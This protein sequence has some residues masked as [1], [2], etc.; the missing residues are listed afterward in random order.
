MRKM[1]RILSFIMA[2]VIFIASA[3][4]GVYATEIDES[5]A[6][7]EE[8]VETTGSLSES[9]ETV[10]FTESVG[11]VVNETVNVSTENQQEL[12]D[13][14]EYDDL[15]EM[16]AVEI[17]PDEIEGEV[18][19]ADELAAL[20]ENRPSMMSMSYNLYWDNYTSYY[21]YNQ[22]S[23]DE[24]KLWDALD[25]LCANYLVD[26]TDLKKGLTDYVTINTTKTITRDE[27]L[28]FANMFKY[29]HPQYYYLRSGYSYHIGATSVTLAFMVY[30]AFTDG[31]ARKNATNAVKAQLDTWCEQIALGS[32]EEEK[33]KIIHDIICDNVDYN[34]GVLAGDN[35]I[36]SEEEETYFTQSA[37]SV[38]CTDLTVCAGYTQTFM[39]LCNAFDIECFGVTSPG[40][41]WNKVKVND[42]WYNLD[43]TWDDGVGVGDRDY[44]CYL[45]NDAYM[46]SI[47]GHEEEEEWL[48]YL[49]SCTLDSGSDYREAGTLQVITQKVAKPTISVVEEG[50]AYAVTIESDT[51]G[52]K[53]FY[54]LDG[55][56]PSEA[57]SKGKLYTGTFRMNQTATIRAIA[58]C[59]GYLDSEVADG[60]SIDEKEYI[61]DSGSCGANVIWE[62]DSKDVLTISGSGDMKSYAS[63]DAVPW[64]NYSQDIQIVEIKDGVT[65]IGDYAFGSVT[66]VEYIELADSITKIGAYA[67]TYN[68]LTRIEIP[69]S[70]R[71]IGDYAFYNSNLVEIEIP[72]GV[73]ELGMYAFASCYELTHVKICGNPTTIG[74]RVFEDCD[75]L[76][77]IELS[78]TC[79]KIGTMMFFGCGGLVSIEL[80]ES[81]TEIGQQALSYCSKLEEIR[82]PAKVVMQPYAFYY[83]TGLKKVT[84]ENGVTAIPYGAFNE[85][86]AL[87][88]IR[89]PKSV[90]SIGN[91][92]IDA[93]ATIYGYAG[94]AAETYANDNGNTFVDIG[95]TEYEVHFVTGTDEQIASIICQKNSLIEEP[96]LGNK[97]G[98]TF[99]GWYTSNTIHDETTKW[100]FANDIVTEEMTLYAYWIPNT[101]QLS[102]DLNYEGVGIVYEKEVTYDAPYGLLYE[103]NRIGYTFLGWYTQSEG[104]EEITPESIYKNA[105]DTTIYAHWRANTYTVTLDANGGELDNTEL[106]VTFDDLYGELPMPTKAGYDFVGWFTDK[107]VGQEI[108]EDTKVT[109]TAPQT[110]YA[111]WK[112]SVYEVTFNTTGGEEITDKIEVTFGEPYGELPVAERVGYTF[113][114][115]YTEAEGGA[116]ITEESIYTNVSDT[117]IYAQWSANTYKIYFDANG[118]IVDITE[119]TVTFDELYG[120]LPIP[121]KEGYSFVGWYT[122]KITGQVIEKDTKVTIAQSQTLYARWEI[123]VCEVT[124]NPNGGTVDQEKINVTYGSLYGE[125]PM[126]V[127]IG[128]TF[129]GWY[130]ELEG[131]IK[132]NA[133][134]IV[135]FMEPKTLYAH[136]E[137][138]YKVANPV[139]R[140]LDGTDPDGAEVALGTR[141][142]LITDT[143]GAK[144]YFTKDAGV[145]LVLSAENGTLTEVAMLYEDAIELTE[146]G[147]LYAIAV[148]EGYTYSEVMTVSY[149]VLDD[150]YNWGDVTEEDIEEQ[151]FSTTADVPKELWV[152][153]VAEE[154]NYTGK[155]ITYPELRVYSYTTLLKEKT[156]Y[157]VKYKN[158]KNAGIATITITGKGNYSGSIVKTFT[159]NPLNLTDAQI[160]DVTLQYN[161][162]VQKP[163][164]TVKYELDGKTVTL[165]KGTDFNYIYPGTD[166]NAEDYDADAFK[167][168]GTYTVYL[169]GKGNY[170]TE[171]DYSVAFEVTIVEETLISKM[172]L[173]KIPNQKYTGEEITPSVTLMRGS[174]KL[175]EGNDYEIVEYINNVGVGTAS[176]VIEGMGDYVGTRTAT[177]KITGTALSKVRMSG[178]AKSLPWTGEEVCQDDVTF[179]YT[180]GKGEEAYT[181]YLEKDIHYTVTYQKNVLVGTATVIFEGIEENGYTGTIKKTYKITGLPMKNVQVTGLLSTIAY[182]GGDNT[183]DGYE[184]VYIEGK[185]EDAQEISL[186][187][188]TEGIGEGDY[189]VSY[190]N[191]GKAGTATITFTGINGYTGSIKKTYKIT[192]YDLADEEGRI[193][194]SEI[195]DQTYLKGGAMPKPEVIYTTTYGEEILLV[196]GK[197]YTLKYSNNKSVA[198]VTMRKAPMVT[199]TGKGNFKGKQMHKFNI[200]GSNLSATTMIAT[201]VVYQNKA[202]IC[203]P[204]IKV[205]DADGK[206]L[207]SNT[208]YQKTVIYKYAADVEVTQKVNNKFVNEM[209]FKGDDV[210]K[211]DIIPVGAEI[212]ATVTGIKNY[213]GTE[214]LPSTQSATFKF[215][216]ADIAKAKV[217]V[218]AQT[219]TGKTVEPTKEDITVKIGKITLEK[220]D[221]EIVGYS[222]NIKKGTA[223]VTIRG[224]GNYGGEKTVTFK[225]N[226]KSMNYTIIF[227]KNADDA[228]GT[229][230]VASISAGK[231]LTANAY[232]NNGYKFVGWNTQADGSGY[233]Y[234]DKEKFYLQGVMWIFGSQ[235]T[236]YAQWEKM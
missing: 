4:E 86:S 168:V 82:I 52:A 229:M 53:I 17:D 118:G 122:D 58:V 104:G 125:L 205:Y 103:E 138:K 141:I 149:T 47:G 88:E 159:I 194:V 48:P 153:G 95:N 185:G 174:K 151:G 61:V 175:E 20:A 28:G 220:T 7:V 27:L 183:Q 81:L 135:D 202:D 112:V 224:I 116:Q 65:S 191:N 221:Y 227:D 56:T 13:V 172:S 196:E 59:D 101:Y 71:V 70:V 124:L 131:G 169:V 94:S 114:G 97:M 3:N 50:T 195:I 8:L 60:A 115:W 163:T 120:E 145:N 34:H 158:N 113:L 123:G 139:A 179:S 44:H 147:T 30:D 1:K 152:A 228:T 236:L 148:K 137:L 128:H 99:G 234:T 223:K 198:D 22:L 182:D 73:T 80:P 210:E 219:Y 232:K 57:N 32:T 162:K 110:L 78:D 15:L 111:R 69:T 25:V 33:V 199:I 26:E 216:T 54:T 55:E 140:M 43:A 136:W 87:E 222:N 79:T 45:K 91:I 29:S 181:E 18:Y 74:E 107:N 23:A 132:V 209:R 217:T 184:L 64:Y 127:K 12:P 164:T 178:F 98:Y 19:D 76:T 39:W 119:T 225:I 51:E 35:Q 68:N 67:F 193:R 231:N 92:A 14:R 66:N 90:T 108:K 173:T 190:K 206:L 106:I 77:E 214:E 212:I 155:A 208:D 161:K 160:S 46:E 84:I 200:I 100:D 129:T 197:D 63:A 215:V 105:L 89:I 218:I 10:E 5:D 211:D 203:K 167:E 62:F 171:D 93:T 176:I 156:D 37:Y 207:K 133:D 109:I 75:K 38:F 40:H 180:V 157:T 189:R 170:Y 233:T 235:I 146:S 143:N 9:T 201:D 177:F 188:D 21:I 83:N 144:I 41:A 213:E 31:T 134:T 166:K 16:E 24:R 102:F 121:V 11:E 42:N 130:T 154:T 2:C 142:Y 230:K 126:P 204:S 187:E 85:C 49:P 192:A 150:S 96:V 117:T 165:K 186:V 6:M 36:S 226:S 72:A